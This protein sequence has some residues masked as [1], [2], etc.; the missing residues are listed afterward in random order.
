[1]QVH[2]FQRYHK[3]ENVVTANT[4]LLLSRI[5]SY[6]PDKFYAIISEMLGQN[7]ADDL[8]IQIELQA[9]EHGKKSIPDAIIYQPA[10]KIVVEVKIGDWFHNGQLYRHLDHLNNEGRRFLLTIADV[11][12]EENKK[13][14]FNKN[15]EKFNNDHPE[16]KIIHINTT[17]SNI[18]NLIDNNLDDR[19]LDLKNVLNDYRDFC[20]IEKLF[21]AEEAANT[22]LLRTAG[23]TM[24]FNR[25]SGIY[26][27]SAS[28][29]YQ[30]HEY[31]GLYN[32]KAIRFIGKVKAIVT[33]KQVDGK[34]NAAVEFPPN[35]DPKEYESK[36]LEAMEDAEKYGWDNLKNEAH[37][38]FFVY[39]FVGTCFRK[40]SP[41][42]CRS[43]KYFDLKDVLHVD[44]L[45][46]STE[47]IAK[48]LEN[49]TW[50]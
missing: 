32:N 22:L 13:A 33:A 11:P 1:M 31:I 49:E 3:K 24:D 8:K 26:Y 48:A 38:Y 28:R 9:G 29:G 17:F 41:G 34:V 7:S 45:P 50:A 25:N 14:A 47:E 35:G 19:D 39:R 18:I 23:T 2:Y 46:E 37:R 12:M 16:S 10:F 27:D 42:G 15:L 40:T 21:S 30:R 4:M 20:S 43:K 44:N 5:Y 6:S 36:I